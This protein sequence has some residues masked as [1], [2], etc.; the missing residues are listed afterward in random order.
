M[1]D[2]HKA[3]LVDIGNTRIKYALVAQLA[4]L[5]QVLSCQEVNELKTK[6]TKCHKVLVSSVG[7]PL[8]E[9]QLAQLCQ[10]AGKPCEFVQTQANTLGVKS[11]YPNFATLGVDRWLAILAANALTS[12]PVAVID[13]GTANTC[14]IL[15]DKQHKGGWIAPGFELMRDV[16][17]QQTQKVFAD[18]SIPENLTLG[19]STQ[20]CVALGCLAAQSGFV[21]QADQYLASRYQQYKILITGGG[22]KTLDLPAELPVEYYVNLVLLGLFQL[23]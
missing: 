22:Q 16:L 13:L 11:A 12:L 14:D 4:D 5:Q 20:Q 21:L 10:Q 7:H 3:L 1:S 15:I 8:Q 23:I 9:Q 18:H 19:T 17:Q 2:L 6:L